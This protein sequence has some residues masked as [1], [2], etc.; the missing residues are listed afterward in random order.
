L[1]EANKQVCQ[2]VNADETIYMFMSC[3][4][5]ARQNYNLMIAN[6]SFKNVAKLKYLGITLANQNCFHEEIK[7]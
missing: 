3:H 5:D 6:K 7:S 4:R 1:L 2:E